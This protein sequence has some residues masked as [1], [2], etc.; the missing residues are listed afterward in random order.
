[1]GT[2]IVTFLNNLFEIPKDIFSADDYSPQVAR[3]FA[4][5]IYTHPLGLSVHVIFAVVFALL[6]LKWL[7]IINIICAMFWATGIVVHRKGY[8]WQGF[9][10]ITI[11]VIA[12]AAISVA[13]LGWAAGFQYYLI[14]F[15]VVAFLSHW[16]TSIKVAVAAMY[17]CYYAV[18]HYYIS[19]LIPIIALPSSY[20]SMFQYGN[21]FAMS[22]VLSSFGYTFSLATVRAETKLEKAHQRTNCVLK[23]LNGELSEA[24]DYV[25]KILPQP[26]TDGAIRTNWRLAPSTS[27]G[28]DAFGYHM[29]DTDHFA[30]YLI[31][32]SGH[33]VGAALLSSSVI[34]MLRSQSLP[35]ADFKDP[36]QVLRS[37]NLAFPSETNKDMFFTMW[38]G[39]YNANSRELTYASG[40]HPP[41]ILFDDNPASDSKIN[42]LK[43]PNYVIGG[44]PEATYLTKKYPVGE[45]NTLY[46][47]SDGVYEVEKRDGSMWRFQEFTDFMQKVK[48]N[49]QPVLDRLYGYVKGL[50]N[51]ET[52]EDDF[53]I[54]EVV[55]S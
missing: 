9:V 25:K 37:L 11:P 44:M 34:N 14:V 39:V 23:R 52:L 13:V 33:G 53:T 43:T 16:S 27:L 40:G 28:G 41:A 36:E 2:T 31:D 19:P 45:R 17:S 47:F 32:V 55:F 29:V 18:I 3:I 15:P 20:I 6:G 5:G 51:S 24:A 8:M 35:N 21:F 26:I 1:M 4:L 48:A 22:I 12:H 10:I 54:L 7:A 46:I 42:L 50:G 30:V 38:Y 49:N